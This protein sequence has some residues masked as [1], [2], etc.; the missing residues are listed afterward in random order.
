MLLESELLL[1]RLPENDGHSEGTVSC[2]KAQHCA[3]QEVQLGALALDIRRT[4]ARIVCSNS[5]RI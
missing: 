3:L 4:L 2:G 1:L 5:A